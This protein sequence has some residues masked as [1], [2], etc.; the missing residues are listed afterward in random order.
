MP[1]DLYI[2]QC[3]KHNQIYI[4]NTFDYQLFLDTI[5]NCQRQDFE[6]VQVVLETN[7]IMQ[8]P[9][10]KLNFLES[11]QAS[12]I[13]LRI[14]GKIDLQLFGPRTKKETKTLVSDQPF[15]EDGRDI[16]MSDFE[17][18]ESLTVADTANLKILSFLKVNQK[19]LKHLQLK[20]Y[21]Y[22]FEN[23]A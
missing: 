20:R 19:V 17:K 12:C 10:E 9:I 13:L 11:F 8:E 6:A 21:H 22:K 1:K 18:L 2:N 4:Y 16:D 3:P 14:G 15:I 5:S 7:E 23:F